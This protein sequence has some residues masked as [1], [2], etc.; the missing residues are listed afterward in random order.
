MS[1]LILHEDGKLTT[2]SGMNPLESIMKRS[3]GKVT[4]PTDVV[5]ISRKDA[6]RATVPA[7][8]IAW[9]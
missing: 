8:Q 4:E 9:F 6:E 2:R 3:A 1:D 5:L 7:K